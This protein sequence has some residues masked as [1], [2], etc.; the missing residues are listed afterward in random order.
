MHTNIIH[1]KFIT[2]LINIYLSIMNYIFVW[3]IY[4]NIYPNN[5]LL[6]YF[7]YSQFYIAVYPPYASGHVSTLPSHILGSIVTH[8]IRL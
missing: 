8:T 2:Y 5:I 6:V 7:V 3:I 4:D 1:I